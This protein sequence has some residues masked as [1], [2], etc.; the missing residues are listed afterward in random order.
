ML[1]KVIAQ[2]IATLEASAAAAAAAAAVRVCVCVR[3]QR[4]LT[5]AKIGPRC[6][7]YGPRCNES[8][9]NFTKNM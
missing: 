4:W 6:Q 2:I 7:I 3:L 5:W 1:A 9:M 8:A